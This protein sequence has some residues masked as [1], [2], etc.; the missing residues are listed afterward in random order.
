MPNV[1]IYEVRGNKM[2]KELHPDDP[3]TAL[4]EFAGLFAEKMP[5]EEKDADKRDFVNCFHFEKEP[6]K[7]YGIPFMFL[8]KPVSDIAIFS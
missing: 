2:Y 7:P 8:V 3:V 1:R 4:S 5:E 6:S